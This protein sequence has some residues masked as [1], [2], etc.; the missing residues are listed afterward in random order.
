MAVR[1]RNN[2]I[3]LKTARKGLVI[4]DENRSLFLAGII[5][6]IVV[7]FLLTRPNAYSITMQGEIIG[8]MKDKKVIEGAKQTVI[9]QLKEQ[10]GTEVKFEE[11]LQIKKYRAKKEDYINETYLIS[12]MR[13]KMNILIQFK[14]IEVDGVPVGI[15]ASE[16]EVEELKEKLK[17]KYYGDRE[18]E[19]TFGKDVA[20]TNVFAKEEDLMPMSKLVQKCATTTPRA[21]TYTVQP[22]DTFSGIAGKYHTTVD[23]IIR[24]N[25]GFTEQT[26]LRVGDVIN[27]NINEPLL[28]LEPVK[29]DQKE[30]AEDVKDEES[31]AI[32]AS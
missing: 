14:Q 30:T 11:E 29:K 17:K 28:P 10:Y 13:E 7:I 6:M 22:G 27:A 4:T 24:A 9:T 32:K 1:R 16:K 26:V 20:V 31:A 21:I 5:A 18:V 2:V 15:V 8:A 25:K 19:V 12:C 23:S 3:K